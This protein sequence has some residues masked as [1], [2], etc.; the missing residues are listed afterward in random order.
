MCKEKCKEKG[1]EEEGEEEEEEDGDS[2]AD[3]EALGSLGTEALA[4]LAAQCILGFA[5]ENK[6]PTGMP[7]AQLTPNLEKLSGDLL[8]LHFSTCQKPISVISLYGLTIAFQSNTCA[9]Y[10]LDI[11]FDK[12]LVYLFEADKD[13]PLNDGLKRLLAILIELNNA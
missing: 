13:L 8:Q 10:K 7:R 5:S 4:A 1:E 6:R 2:E 12:K 9:C 3:T 11:D